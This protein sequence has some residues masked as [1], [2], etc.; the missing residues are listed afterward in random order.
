M[1]A[2]SRRQLRDQHAALL[3]HRRHLAEEVH[4]IEEALLRGVR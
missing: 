2:L 4:A 1:A 3:V